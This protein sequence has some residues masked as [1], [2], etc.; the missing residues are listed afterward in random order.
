MPILR[1]G[2]ARGGVVCVGGDEGFLNHTEEGSR[3]H[4]RR[5]G[6]GNIR[7]GVIDVAAR[8]C[9]RGGSIVIG[10][11]YTG[12]SGSLFMLWAAYC[13]RLGGGIYDYLPILEVPGRSEGGEGALA[14]YARSAV[15]MT[16]RQRHVP[17]S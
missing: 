13:S 3:A 15:M 14:A 7:R 2:N 8:E 1:D 16:P 10:W 6:M 5:R 9:A 11:Q 17:D 12:K 4:R